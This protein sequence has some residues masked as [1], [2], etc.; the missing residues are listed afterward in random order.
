MSGKILELQPLI[1]K[2]NP[3]SKSMELEDGEP[4]PAAGIFALVGVQAGGIRIIRL[5]GNIPFQ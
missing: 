4:W 1:V 3:W 5:G 2:A